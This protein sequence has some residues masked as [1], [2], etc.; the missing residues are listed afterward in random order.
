MISQC[1]KC[2]S[3]LI[4]GCSETDLEWECIDCGYV[5]F[6]VADRGVIL[7]DGFSEW[8]RVDQL[9]RRAKLL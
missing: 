3:E 4:L 6:E 7:T 5:W 8:A 9:I 1:Q 2:G